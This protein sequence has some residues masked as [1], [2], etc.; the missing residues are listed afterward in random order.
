MVKVHAQSLVSFMIRCSAAFLDKGTHRDGE[1][2]VRRRTSNGDA[3]AS[4]RTRS[5][6]S[7]AHQQS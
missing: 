7:G 1:I 4:G 2:E 3:A 6:A 5:Y